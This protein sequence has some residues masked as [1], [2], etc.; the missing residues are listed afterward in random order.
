MHTSTQLYKG[1]LSAAAFAVPEDSLVVYLTF[2]ATENAELVEVV[3]QGN[4]TTYS[5]PLDYKLLPGFISNRLQGLFANQNA[6]QRTVFFE[7]GLK[8]FYRSPIIGLGMGAYE[9]GIRSV[10]SFAYDT[11]YAHNHYIQVLAETGVVGL[12]LFLG[13]LLTAA[14]ALWRSRQQDHASLLLP[15]LTGTLVFMAGHAAVEVIF[16]LYA[17][18]PFAFG[19]FALISLCAG[20]SISIPAL[21]KQVQNLSIAAVAVLLSIFA[22]FLVRNM[23]AKAMVYKDGAT[24]A[25]LVRAAAIDKFE[26][27]DYA[28]SYVAGIPE[29]PA[30]YIRIQADAYAA[31]LAKLDSN[32]VPRY[33]IQYYF[34]TGQTANAFA[35]AEK[36]VDYVAAAP[37][38]WQTTFDLIM[39]YYQDTAEFRAGTLRIEEKMNVWNSA[40][41]GSIKL[42]AITTTFLE[43]LEG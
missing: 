21:N 37:E 13:V 41:M 39:R 15:A 32:S 5:V 16:S 42:D 40:N 14:F 6:I 38:T 43:Q 11:K 12:V 10:Q 35:M 8:L 24:S 36:Y 19:V 27:A 30:E 34:K 4:S 23:Q 17:F 28:L 7:D 2:S 18:L 31:R 29:E 20:D 33:L 22:F 9:N 25:D 1:K 26:W 3:L